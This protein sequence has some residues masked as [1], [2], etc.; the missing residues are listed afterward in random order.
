MD[1][2]LA[3]N[4]DDT[5]SYGTDFNRDAWAGHN[6]TYFQLDGGAGIDRLDLHLGGMTIGVTIVGPTGGVESNGQNLL[7][8]NGASAHNFEILRDIDTGSG[9][10]TLIQLGK[11]NNSW[12]SAGGM[13]TIK[14]GLGDDFV[15]AGVETDGLVFTTNSEGV[16]VAQVANPSAYYGSRGDLLVLDYSGLAPGV[17]VDSSSSLVDTDLKLGYLQ[18]AGEIGDFWVYY[19]AQG[20]QSSYR[21]LYP[22]GSLAGDYLISIFHDRVDVTGSD[23]DDII[24]GAWVPFDSDLSASLKGDDILR[25]G[26]GNDVLYGQTGDDTLY[27][28][29]GSDRLV[30]SVRQDPDT[31]DVSYDNREIDHLWGGSGADTFV[32]GEW[33]A[34]F[35]LNSSVNNLTHYAV[36]EDWTSSDTLQLTG[37]ISNYTQSTVNVLDTE[38]RHQN[39]DLIA[40]IRGGWFWNFN[41]NTDAVSATA[42]FTAFSANETQNLELAAPETAPD[43]Q[44]VETL[45][46]AALTTAGS[47]TV[48]ATG[49]TNLLLQKLG[50]P[51]GFSN[52]SL[53]YLRQFSKRWAGSKATPSAWAAASCS[54]PAG[55]KTCPEP[56]PRRARRRRP[57]MKRRSLSSR[58]APSTTA[59]STRPSLAVLDIDMR[60]ITLHDSNLRTEGGDG[61]VSGF[62]LNSIMLSTIDIPVGGSLAGIN[63]MS[64]LNVFDF[65]ALGTHYAAGDQR[66]DPDNTNVSAPN[67]RG[68]LTNTTVNNAR[69][70]LDSVDTYDLSQNGFVS[71]G[72]G[73]SI[74]FDLTQTVSTDGPLFLYVSEADAST[75]ETL[76]GLISASTQQVEPTGDLSTDLGDQGLG[77][78]TTTLTYHFTP[79]ADNATVQFQV[80]LFSEELPEFAGKSPIDV[81]KATLNGVTIGTLSDGRSATLDNLMVTTYGPKHHDLVLNAPVIGAA[82]DLIRADAYTTVLTFTGRADIGVDNIL[83]LEVADKGDAFLDTGMLIRA[84]PLTGAPI[85]GAISVIGSGDPVE[86]GTNAVIIVTRPAD[87]DLDTTVAVTLTPSGNIGLGGSG[88]GGAAQTVTFGAGESGSKEIVVRAIAGEG[89]SQGGYVEASVTSDDPDFTNPT[90]RRVGFD[91]VDTYEVPE[92]SLDVFDLEVPGVP[93]GVATNWSITGGIDA[94]KFEI[95]A[96]T[97]Q[98][99]FISAPDFEAPTRSGADNDYGVEVTARNAAGAVIDT[100]KIN[101]RVTDV[102]ETSTL[103]VKFE[104]AKAGYENTLGWYDSRTGVGGIVFSSINSH[105]R[106][107]FKAGETA[108][109][110]VSS[111]A[112]PHIQFFLIPDGGGQRENSNDELMGGVKIVQQAN[113]KWAIATLDKHG[114]VETD[115]YGKPNLLVG[116]DAAALFS[117]TSKNAGNVDYAS[118]KV[119]KSQ[120]AQ[121]L[122]GDTADGPT[123]LMAWEDIAAIKKSNGTYGA[124]GDADYDD[125]VFTVMEYKSLTLTGTNAAE[126]LTGG[127]ASDFLL[128]KAG[129]DTLAG[130]SGNDRLDGGKDA[131][132]MSGGR[133]DDIYLVDNSGDQVIEAKGEGDD[134]VLSGVSYTL[135][136]NTERLVLTGTQAINGTGNDLDNKITGNDAANTL[137]GKKGDDTLIGLGGDDTYVVDSDCD[138]VVEQANSG[139]DVVWSSASFELGV[140]IEN[141]VLAGTSS[142]SGTGN[143]LAN[144]LIGNSGANRLDGEGGADR[145]EGKGGNDTYFVDNVADEVVETAY[146]G[147]DTVHSAVDFVLAAYVENLTLTGQAAING[148]GNSGANTLVGNRADNILDGAGGADDLKGGDGDDTYIIDNANDDVYESSSDGNDTV[149]SSVSF[150]LG[151]NVENLVLTGTAAINGTGNSLGNVLVG[152]GAN[153]LLKAGSGGDLL[154]GGAGADSLYGGSDSSRDVFVF[155]T[156][157]DSGKT[158]S[159]WDRIY[160]F[161]R[162]IDEIDLSDIDAGSAVGDQAFRFVSNFSAGSIGQVRAVNSGSDVRVEIDLQGDNVVDMVLQ[163][164]GTSNLRSGDF[165]L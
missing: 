20:N 165:I 112:V 155:Q 44:S 87:A 97:G 41:L 163:I 30:G 60:S 28:G 23:G 70:T 68:A 146:G 58:S 77:G 38:V 102:S 27:G 126:A 117:D 15:N 54:A 159:T 108:S 21:T 13:D 129:N 34:N 7:L 72:D 18:D 61:E 141:L 133:G 98:L 9:D 113:G 36:I 99:S 94:A 40:V 142:I 95:D 101:A 83:R 161:D 64:R 147:T 75:G 25:G 65:S 145:M 116:E 143:G 130:H 66:Y 74:G 35:Y 135:T 134:T 131:D 81:I 73:G 128:G 71:L 31:I 1:V 154:V 85:P 119:G 43:G 96:A 84:L 151:N 109:F 17:R 80:V 103:K 26:N 47:F 127:V 138:V 157:A 93:A 150:T 29:T 62:D 76:T 114:N 42:G 57:S 162:N 33:D 149:R 11:A 52:T 63:T 158:S 53:D 121:T 39:G 105:G 3:G 104:M 118:S 4:G 51:T 124:P 153:N 89:A 6:P 136:A 148:L 67:L 59:R 10:D 111:E 120:T 106:C 160:D 48:E 45:S 69:A 56:I 19:Q 132:K 125:A 78:D 137:D 14:S 88:A 115:R 156:I 55:S 46:V 86:D 144:I 110:E 5:V 152:N 123:G 12:F 37:P 22:D 32:V 2:V 92:N 91:I 139:T 100:Q 16:Y 164:V 90:I 140:N 24:V 79:D 49:D 122:A 107:H 50:T 82:A 8:P